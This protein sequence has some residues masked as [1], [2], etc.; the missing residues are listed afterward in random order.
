MI[1]IKFEYIGKF[2]KL[3]EKRNVRSNSIFW[4]FLSLFQDFQHI[5]SK[6][7]FLAVFVQKIAQKLILSIRNGISL[8]NVYKIWNPYLIG[9]I[10]AMEKVQR[11]TTRIPPELSSFEYDNRLTR[12]GLTSLS[13]RRTRGNLIQMFKVQNNIEN[14]NWQV[15]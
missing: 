14:I 2:L 4:V 7:H 15:H 1:F 13:E 10:E 9:D 11:R 8:R 12:W 5:L 3:L 6:N